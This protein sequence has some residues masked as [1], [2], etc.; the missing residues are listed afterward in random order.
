MFPVGDTFASAAARNTSSDTQL[1]PWSAACIS[2]HIMGSNLPIKQNHHTHRLF[3]RRHPGLKENPHTHTYKSIQVRK[4]W[5]TQSQSC[6]NS[7][8]PGRLELEVGSST[9][10]AGQFKI[11]KV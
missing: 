8:T 1:L 11:S 2:L 3:S 6:R 10:G 9:S 5:N 7:R 4:E